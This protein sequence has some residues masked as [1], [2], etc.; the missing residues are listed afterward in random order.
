MNRPQLLILAASIALAHAAVAAPSAAAL[1][2]SN[3]FAKQSSLPLNYP[4][5]DKIKDEHFLPAYAAGMREQLREVDVIAN[6]KAAPSFA[7]TIVAMERSGQLLGRVSAVFSNLQTANTNDRLDAIDREMSPKLAAHN[8]AIYLNPKLFQRVKTLHDKRASLKLDAESN[9]LLER[10]YKE[11][12]RAGANLS[13]ADKQ[14][15][16][17]YNG[18]IASLQSE[19]S[20]RVLKEANASALVVGSREEL[21]GMSEAEI[22]AAAAEAEKRGQK[23]KYA[24]AIVNTSSQPALATLTN[25]AT[26]E[27]LMQASLNRGSRGGEFDARELVLRLVKLRAE[28]AA[29]LG[30]PNY[31]AYSQELETAKNPAAVNKLLGELAGPAVNN[32]KKE[33]AEIQKVID[34]E[35]GGFQI[36]SWDWPIYQDKVRAA[37]YNFDENQLRPYFELNRVLVDGVFFAATKEFGIT[38]KERKDLPVYDP[39]VRVFDVFDHDGKQLAIFLF[40]PYARANKQGGAWM[41]EYV[42]QSTLLNRRPVV[43]NHLNIPKPPAGEPTLLTYDEVRTA[44]HEF[45]HALHGMFSNVKYPHFS[46][47]SVPRDFVEYP[48]QVNEMWA[49]WPEV[50]SNYARHHKTGAA[51][52]KELLDKVVASKKFNQGYLTTEYLAASLIDQRWHQLTPSEIPTDVLAFEA[53]ALKDAGADFAPVPPRYRTTYF[54]H[55]MNGGYSAGYYAY[56]W[57]EKL[58]ADTVEWFKQ[59]GG[60]SRK[61]GDHFR[62]TLLSRGGTADAMDLFRNFRGRDPIIEPLLER[63]GLTGN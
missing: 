25:R 56:L 29:L 35:K 41:N 51:M 1:D 62:K 31:A 12:V 45:G 48:S 10:V 52:P 34:A 53:K 47:T 7:N 3:P 28:R 14:K 19:F 30:Y 38:F 55:S 2:A 17:A 32:A 9:H 18:E 37:R 21:A 15:L 27:R 50:L 23:G 6:S 20:Q 61:N 26:R 58:D 57:S 44:F 13:D 40:D 8:D 16:K 11:F 4:A 43:G 60:L 22:A 5:F 39:D 54:S 46:G 63:R 49:I 24:I 33:A 59:N 42:S 36:A